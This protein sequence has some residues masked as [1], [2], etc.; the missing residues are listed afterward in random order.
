MKVCFTKPEL[1]TITSALTQS[2]ITNFQKEFF[3]EIKGAS[4]YFFSIGFT[5]SS[6]KLGCAIL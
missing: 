2:S 1:T 6:K 3:G 4:P 5:Y